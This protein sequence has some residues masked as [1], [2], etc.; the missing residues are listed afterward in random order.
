MDKEIK[1]LILNT[2]QH[3]LKRHQLQVDKQAGSVLLKNQYWIMREAETGKV[4]TVVLEE[5]QMQMVDRIIKYQLIFQE[6]RNL[7]VPLLPNI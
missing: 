4:H 7:Q 5:K 6:G 2:K 3:M 1:I